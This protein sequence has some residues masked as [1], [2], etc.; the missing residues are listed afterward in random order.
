MFTKFEYGLILE[1][2]ILSF[3]QAMIG[4][5]IAV[6]IFDPILRVLLFATAIPVTTLLG[7]YLIGRYSKNNAEVTKEND[8]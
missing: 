1:Y 4:A 8:K 7:L 5:V 6:V 2:I 3:V